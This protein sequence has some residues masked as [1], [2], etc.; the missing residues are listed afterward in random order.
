MGLRFL[1]EEPAQRPVQTGLHVDQA[2]D[3]TRGDPHRK[4]R[5]LKTHSAPTPWTWT[6]ATAETP[7]L[8]KATN[9]VVSKA[10]KF[11]KKTR[12]LIKALKPCVLHRF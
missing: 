10:G 11:N 9:I 4:P 8:V 12:A 1:L 2:Q 7:D 3:R 5:K 6:I